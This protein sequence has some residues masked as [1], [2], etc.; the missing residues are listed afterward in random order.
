M[1]L[2]VIGDIHG[3]YEEL[4]ELIAQL[5]YIEKNGHFYHDDH[6][7]LAFVGDLTDRGPASLRVIELVY[8]LVV[9][10]QIAVYVPG[11]HCDK[12]YRY[13]LG[14]NVDVKHG[15]ETTITEY[16][17][18]NQTDKDQIKRQF[19]TLYNQAPLYHYDKHLNVVISH[20]GILNHMIG[21]TSKHVK[22]FVLYGPKPKEYHPDGRP[23]RIDWTPHHNGETLVIYGH[24][25]VLRP[26]ISNNTVNIDL[27]CIFG[28]KLMAMRVP[29]RTMMTVDSRQPFQPER[30][31]DFEND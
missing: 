7:R 25:P 8:Q 20:A 24:T 14:N 3:C 12:L 11:N 1:A 9:V 31:T 4:V 26:Y 16:N 18:L 19:M 15:L 22:A 23:V 17:Q 27:G 28:N 29:E 5:G 6:R 2:D 13:F 10:D 30:F 21:Q